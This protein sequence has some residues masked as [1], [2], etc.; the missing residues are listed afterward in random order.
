MLKG[1]VP[2]GEGPALD[3]RRALLCFLE[4]PSKGGGEGALRLR[5]AF[6]E[7][8]ARMALRSRPV[9]TP[10]GVVHPDDGLEEVREI[11]G[12][13]LPLWTQGE[14]SRGERMA[15]AAG[16]AFAGG[17]EKVLLI[18]TD[19]PDLPMGHCLGAARRLD[20]DQVVLGP[21]REGGCYLVGL[22]RPA[23]GILLG[24]DWEGGQVIQQMVRR[25]RAA[26]LGLSYLPVWDAVSDEGGLLALRERLGH[27]SGAAPGGPDV[28][29]PLRSAVEEAALREEGLPPEW[30]R[31]ADK[32]PS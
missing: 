20:R 31:G 13:R 2:G 19:T 12:P 25:V 1:I 7:S 26:G 17:A 8:T 9:L 18:G 27:P 5:R 29:A 22:E 24:F 10:V 4:Q 28:L 32:N 15:R 21:T 6:L 16:R 11:A 23:P 3:G 30:T 14:G